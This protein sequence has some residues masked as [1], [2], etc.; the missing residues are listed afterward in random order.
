LENNE[1]DRISSRNRNLTFEYDRDTYIMDYSDG[2]KRI[3]GAADFFQGDY[4]DK[5]TSKSSSDYYAFVVADGD[6][7]RAIRITRGSVTRDGHTIDNDDLEEIRITTGEVQDMDT[8]FNI[9][10]I[11]KASNWSSFYGQWE[12]ADGEVHVNC[13]GALVLKDGRPMEAEDLRKGERVYVIRD[14]ARGI[15]ILSY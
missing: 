6:R 12:R 4:A 2:S 11:S 8:T 3:I 10:T 9:M 1:W 5:Y 7:A 15:I 13:A 14:D